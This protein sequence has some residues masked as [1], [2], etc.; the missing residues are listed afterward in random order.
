MQAFSTAPSCAY[1]AIALGCFVHR[2]ADPSD[3]SARA[4]YDVLEH[5]NGSYITRHVG[6]MER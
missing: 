1:V 5:I 2:T 6:P 4:L 3:W